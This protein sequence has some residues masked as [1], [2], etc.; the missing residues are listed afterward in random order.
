MF[1]P[2]GCFSARFVTTGEIFKEIS[3]LYFRT[4]H[5]RRHVPQGKTYGVRTVPH[6]H[7]PVPVL[8]SRPSRQLRETCCRRGRG[9]S[10]RSPSLIIMAIIIIIYPY[11]HLAASWEVHCPAIVPTG[12]V[13][14]KDPSSGGPF[15]P[16]CASR[17]IFTGVG[18]K[19]DGRAVC[20][21]WGRGLGATC[22]GG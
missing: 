1:F 6:E 10:G 7:I 19:F 15:K 21:S 9:E 11:P 16:L 2:S 20:P 22:P 3:Y 8:F 17:P 5:M 14:L 18:L 4:E 12:L 13:G